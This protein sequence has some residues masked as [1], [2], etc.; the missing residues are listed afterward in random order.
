[1]MNVKNNKKTVKIKTSFTAQR[2]TNYSGLL[3][4]F[5]FMH[6]LGFF[7]KLGAVNLPL[8]RN[9][10][11]STQSIYGIIVLGLI[12]GMNRISK[13]ES[14][15]RDAL[16]QELFGLSGHIDE[17]TIANR[18]KRFSFHH[19]NN[20]IEH[21]GQMSSKV[22]KQL[23]TDAD[24]LDMDSTV[25]TTYGNQEGVSRGFNPHKKGASSY[26]PLLVF[27]NSTKECLLSWLRPGDAYTA[28]NSSEF[29]KQAFSLL[30]SG[31]KDILVRADSGFFDGTLLSTIESYPGVKYLIKVKLKNLQSVLLSQSWEPIPGKQNYEMTK[32]EYKC[33]GWKQTR[34]FVA[35]RILKEKHEPGELLPKQ[36]YE[37]FCYVTNIDAD[38][39]AIHYLYGDR[40]TSENWI[41]AVKKQMFA[42]SMLTQDFWAN[43]ALWQASILAYNITVWM[44]FLTD[45]KAARQEPA[46]FRYW[47]VL[48]AGKISKTARQVNLKMYDAYHYKDWWRR[49]EKG[50]DDIVFR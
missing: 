12:A 23:G 30:P 38:P 50:V 15:S 11:Y 5:K 22:H 48:L 1:M 29:I 43:E 14:F 41:E 9:I 46:T 28:N 45:L 3:P 6:K 37:M 32:F 13:M 10:K 19:T 27:L 4:V 18:I 26:H 35:V 21:I 16:I 49:I 34:K 44:R 24:I 39:L 2:L 20:L 42:G 25:K 36:G 17:D 7:D 31:I 47:F 8:G 33:A 40:G